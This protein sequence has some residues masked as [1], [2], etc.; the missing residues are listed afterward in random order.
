M[1]QTQLFFPTLK[2]DPAEA[3]VM[4][5][6]LMMRAGMIRKLAAGIYNYL[7]V[8]LRVIRKV[9]AI[10]REGD[11]LDPH[12][13]REDGDDRRRLARALGDPELPGDVARGVDRRER[14]ALAVEEDDPVIAGE[15]EEAPAA[16]EALAGA[17]SAAA[18]PISD[19]RGTAD[20]RTEVA[21]VLARR[22]AEIA[23]ARAKGHAK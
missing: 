14:R 2:E 13:P 9:E 7:P 10:V 8:G 18:R 3:E 15:R 12:R 6:R 19:K 4:S 1:R 5:H 17:A 21:G 16:L 11:P 20:F 23:Y 22:V